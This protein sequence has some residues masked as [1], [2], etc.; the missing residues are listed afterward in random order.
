MQEYARVC[1]SIEPYARVKNSMQKHASRQVC[2]SMQVDKSMQEYARISRVPKL[3]PKLVYQASI[4]LTF[5]EVRDGI[6]DCVL[7]LLGV[8]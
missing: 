5:H 1:K 7:M 2:K 4:H 8:Y 3:E 6:Q